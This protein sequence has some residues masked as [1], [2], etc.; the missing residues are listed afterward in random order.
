[1]VHPVRRR[2]ECHHRLRSFKSRDAGSDFQGSFVYE[3]AF[4]FRQAETPLAVSNR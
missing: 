1:M 4:C 2:A 3:S